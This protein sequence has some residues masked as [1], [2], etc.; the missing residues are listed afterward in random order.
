MLAAVAALYGRFH[1][2]TFDILSRDVNFGIVA[3]VMGGMVALSLYS[4][5]AYYRVDD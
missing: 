1:P 3:G 2:S 4:C 5:F